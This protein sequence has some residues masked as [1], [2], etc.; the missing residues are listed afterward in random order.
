MILVFDTETTG[1]IEYKKMWDLKVQPR[2]AQLGAILYD[3]NAE[4]KG[5]LNLLIKPDGWTMPEEVQA[6]HG[7]STED[8]QKY[9]VDIRS[10][11]AMFNMWLKLDPLLVA[12]NTDFD[13]FLIDSEVKRLGK[14]PIVANAR[15]FCTM[16]SSTNI[17]KL[18]GPRGF[19][20]P[21][22][23]ELHEFLFKVR[24]EGAHDAMADVRACGKSFFELRNKYSDALPK[25][26]EPKTS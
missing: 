13:E 22:L 3:E 1:K 7:I 26:Q 20:W 11:L 23:Q 10:A 17:V 2:I 16:K 24:F 9:G 5:E 25:I 4:V 14:N 19:K 15:K 8:C 6:I 21:Q 12:H 18:P